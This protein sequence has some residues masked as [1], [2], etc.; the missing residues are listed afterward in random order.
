MTPGLEA[1]REKVVRER[2][3]LPARAEGEERDESPSPAVRF[4]LE[5][6]EAAGLAL[7]WRGQA[8]PP[9]SYTDV[10]QVGDDP[11]ARV[12]V[13]VSQAG[14]HA[15]AIDRLVELLTTTMAVRIPDASES[16]LEVGDVAFGGGG[17][18]AGLVLFVRGPIFFRVSSEGGTGALVGEIARLIDAQASEFLATDQL[19]G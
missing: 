15:Q 7:V 14:S 3:G 2:Y 19:D 16:G 1:A 9:G 6:P 13:L 11:G 18:A 10:F 5:A 4:A 8:Y 17:D 12:A